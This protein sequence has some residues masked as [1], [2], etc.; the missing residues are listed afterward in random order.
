MAAVI[1]TLQGIVEYVHGAKRLGSETSRGR[2]DEGAK[3]PI[4]ERP[5]SGAGAAVNLH[6]S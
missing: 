3:R 6:S 4:T 5:M 1:C 2:T